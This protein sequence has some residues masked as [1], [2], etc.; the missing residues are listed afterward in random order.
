MSPAAAAADFFLSL[1]AT[2]ASLFIP[3]TSSQSSLAS[4]LRRLYLWTAVSGSA[5]PLQMTRVWYAFE[6]EGVS[7]IQKLKIQMIRYTGS[8]NLV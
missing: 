2:A 5:P 3:L 8:Q 4:H 6:I 7:W 1:P